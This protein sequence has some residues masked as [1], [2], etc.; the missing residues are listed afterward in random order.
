MKYQPAPHLLV[1]KIHD[2]TVLLNVE[3]NICF[4]LDDVGTRMWEALTTA[5][6]V[7]EAAAV[8]SS[9]YEVD[10]EELRR[11]LAELARRLA[12]QDLLQVAVEA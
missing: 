8:L 6:T 2:E 3:T 4:G 7:E 9:Y 10:P 11:D 5:G 12:E 1:Q